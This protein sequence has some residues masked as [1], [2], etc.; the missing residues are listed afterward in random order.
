MTL[1]TITSASVN[2]NTWYHVTGVYDGNAMRLYVDGQLQ[3][4]SL[5]QSDDI[6]YPTTAEFVIGAYKDDTQTYY[7]NGKMTRLCLHNRELNEQ[8]IIRT[9]NADK[10][11]ALTA[12][13][14]YHH[15]HFKL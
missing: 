7:F 4:S 6:Y 3:T 8:D 5:L 14:S 11:N 2:T 15:V 1:T 13:S 12:T 10:K 9:M